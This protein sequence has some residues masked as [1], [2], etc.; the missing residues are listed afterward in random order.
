MASTLIGLC[1]FNV[2]SLIL[3]GFMRHYYTTNQARPR[4]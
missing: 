1:K 2:F 4:A 3:Q